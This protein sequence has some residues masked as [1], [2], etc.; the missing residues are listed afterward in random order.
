MFFF[1][2]LLCTS[3]A[4]V[5]SRGCIPEANEDSVFRKVTADYYLEA[6]GD[7]VTAHS[8]KQFGFHFSSFHK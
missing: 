4:E 2:L 3:K 6:E 1:F 7:A 8:G 5:E